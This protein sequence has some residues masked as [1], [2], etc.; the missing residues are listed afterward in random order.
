[1]LYPQVS[2][3]GGLEHGG[4][5]FLSCFIPIKYHEKQLLHLIIQR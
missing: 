5:E 3:S 4:G 1:M 2:D